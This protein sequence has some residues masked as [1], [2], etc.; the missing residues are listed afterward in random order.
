[1][2]FLGTLVNVGTVLAGSA[3]GL[4]LKKIFPERITDTLLQGVGLASMIIGL[5]GT[6]AGAFTIVDGSISTQYIMLMILS[7]AIGGLLGELIRIEDGLAAFAKFASRE[8]I[9]ETDGTS[10]RWST[11]GFITAT[12]V[13]CVGSMAIVGAIE[14][15][16]NNNSD[17]LLAKA[18]LDGITSM[19]LASTLGAGVLFSA[20]AVGLYQ[21]SITLLA[22]VAAPY[23][24]DAVITQMS[25]VGSVLIMAIGLNILKIA[26]IKVGNFLPAIF[27][28]LVYY[29][30]QVWAQ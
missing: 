22:S 1:M 30:I 9:A 14:E 29:L 8:K 12:L 19:I 20:F 2:I 15:G 21:G 6:L 4:L 27:I 13:F 23:L 17:I 5:S 24:G 11:E 7:L 28:P 26:K 25:L 18:I 10:P 3:A 16:I